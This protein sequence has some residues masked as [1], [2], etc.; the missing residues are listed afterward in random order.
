M[1]GY[2][3]PKP[4][5]AQ[6]AV[7]A[8]AQRIRCTDGVAEALA[9]GVRE[10]VLFTTEDYKNGITHS[11]VVSPENFTIVTAGFYLITLTT[12]FSFTGVAAEPGGFNTRI[13][14][15]VA[16]LN[17]VEYL[18]QLKI[19]AADSLYT[20]TISDVASLAAGDVVSADV[21]AIF[22][23]GAAEVIDAVIAIHRLS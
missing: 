23:A 5:S 1:L 7:G 9:T 10:A 18:D 6:G 14:V 21:Q 4:G 11:N 20:Q 12:H 13:L 16:V 19:S 3:G 15:G 8:M 22:A 17:Y 2:G